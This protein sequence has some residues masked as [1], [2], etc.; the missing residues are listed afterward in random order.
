[1]TSSES[2]A[3]RNLS[4]AIAGVIFGFLMGYVVAHEV[5]GGRYGRTP[6]SA[7]GPAPAMTGSGMA[8]RQGGGPGSPEHPPV[9]PQSGEGGENTQAMMEQVARDLEEMKKRVAENPKDR[10]ALVRLA[11]IY[12][13]AGMYDRSVEFLQQ[14]LTV[15]PND[16]H[17]RTDLGS[18]LLMQGK[19]EEAVRELQQAVALDAGHGKTWYTL[20]FAL[21]QVGRYDEGEK[22][23]EKSLELSPG[24]FDITHLKEEIGK[25]KAARAAAPGSGS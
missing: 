3:R 15:D 23:F 22:A 1:M 12:R 10:E 5:Y 14:A 9:G 16:V 18:S 4:F 25:L 19:S 21:V 11:A 6:P 7:E 2:P 8:S 24:A 17:A 20:G 13:D